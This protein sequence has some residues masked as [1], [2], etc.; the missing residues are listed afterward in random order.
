MTGESLLTR[1]QYS[2]TAVKPMEG[3]IDARIVEWTDKL[4]NDFVKSGKKID[5][6]PWITYVSST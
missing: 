4:E 3:L 2:M 5:F 6:A 1:E